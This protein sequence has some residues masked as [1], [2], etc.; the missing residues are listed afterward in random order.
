MSIQKMSVRF[1]QRIFYIF[2]KVWFFGWFSKL[3]I[4]KECQT[5]K[6]QKK[7]SNFFLYFIKIYNNFYGE[8]K[9]IKWWHEKIKKKNT[10]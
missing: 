2:S 7:V 3:L 5:K 6:F 4:S 1:F 8:V 10:T 9:K